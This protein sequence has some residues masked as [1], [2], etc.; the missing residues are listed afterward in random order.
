MFTSGAQPTY[1]MLVVLL[2]MVV[3]AQAEF[4]TPIEH[5]VVLMLE[6]RAF[7][8]MAGFFPN[9]DGLNGTEFNPY[10]TS[11]VTQGGVK[12]TKNSPYVSPIDPDHST[13][14]TTSKIFG[15][16]CLL[17]N[18][19]SPGSCNTPKMDGFIEW[20][21][22]ARGH[23]VADAS[24]L[25]DMFTPERLPIMSTLASEFAIFDRFFASHP[26][27][28]WPNRLFQIMGTSKGCTATS[29]RDPK[30]FLYFGK[31]IFDT[32]EEAGHSWR[33]YFKD[34]P[35]EAGLIAKLTFDPFKLRFWESFK[36]DAA[37]GKLPAFSWLN[38]RWFVDK[39]TNE[40]S[41]DQHPDHDV[42]LGEALIKEV[43]E[44]LRSG[45]SWNKTALIIT[46]DEHGGFY[47]HVKPPMNV[48]A[49]DDIASF[50]DKGFEFTRLGMRIPTLL[51]SPW[52]KKG[53]VITHPKPEEKPSPN[54][55][56]DLTSVISTVKKMFNAPKFLTK[57]DA[58]SATFETRFNE[59]SKARTDCPMTLPPA[60]TSLGA[61]HAE[62]EAI[63]PLNHL[64]ED[65]V[66]HFHLLRRRSE[67]LKRSGNLDEPF[68]FEAERDLLPKT[69]GEASD[70]ISKIV[71]EHLLAGAEAASNTMEEQ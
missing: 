22:K 14:A 16:D 54:S 42:R 27:P 29:S 47:D 41:S 28:T 35:L 67:M 71:R 60:P 62:K 15:Q 33:Y 48:P 2:Y 44:T 30:T 36:K 8:H 53:S 34:A 49:P 18:S 6:N 17:K 4:M 39:K 65:I 9:V 23:S 7:D 70:W 58:W 38:P 5:V 1:N 12:V 10:N 37:E 64:Q 32:V 31:T 13:T 56:Y 11:N 20:E 55:E 3:V 26:G 66:A 50:P 59:L 24:K 61:A 52:V 40:G 19:S 51:V 63:L 57:R 46:Y 21:M 25:M 69:Q 45:K 43:Y 68:D